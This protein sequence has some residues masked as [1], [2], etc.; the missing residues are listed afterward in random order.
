MTPKKPKKPVAGYARVSKARD[1]MMAPD[2][3][4]RQIED[5]CRYKG[6]DLAHVFHDIDYSGRRGSK[7]RPG[8]EELLDRR[9]EYSAVVIPKLSRFGRSLSDLAEL[10]NTFDDDGIGLVFLDVDVD[11]KTS[12][13]RL[14]RNIMASLAEYEGDLI[15]DRWKDVHAYLAREGRWASGAILPYGFTWDVEKKNLKVDPAQ[16]KI[17]RDIHRRFQGGASIRAITK[18][19]NDR[20]VPSGRGGQ[21]WQQSVV[22]VLDSPVYIGVRTHNGTET[23]GKWRPILDR[24]TF[25]ATRAVRKAQA[26]GRPP[27]EGKGDYML[28]GLLV[29][30]E[31]GRN[32]HHNTAHG[33]RPALYWC[34]GASNHGAMKVCK[35]GAIAAKR[36]ESFVV[37]QF[38]DA[39]RSPFAKAAMRAPRGLFPVA[40]IADDDLDSRIER[41][42]KRMGRLVDQLADAGPAQEKSVKDKIAKLEMELGEIDDERTRRRASNITTRRKIDDLDHLRKRLSNLEAIW[43]KANVEEQREMLTVAID[44]VVLVP[45]PKGNPRGKGLP[46]GR[47]VRIEWA[48]W[49][50]KAA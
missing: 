11:T 40:V 10:F 33:N 35:G 14:V 24:E 16:A 5:Y 19:L 7:P 27:R 21:W 20:G 37:D 39:V 36:A 15:A 30:G 45:R 29:C 12:T 48:D 49:M 4:Q 50:E 46:Q 13:G 6:L 38:M 31:C 41:I 23:E 1:D 32:L 44:K 8:L 34:R 47:E 28:S 22:R 25:E 43:S 18:A 3:Y 42:D 26:T 9:H 17:V 2:I